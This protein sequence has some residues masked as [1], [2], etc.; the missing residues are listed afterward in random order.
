M[1]TN[2]NFDFIKMPE[3]K[4]MLI[5]ANEALNISNT[6]NKQLIFVYSVPKVGSTTII[7]SLR[8][9][10]LNKLDLIH[11]HDEEMLNVLCHVNGVSI[12]EIILYNKYLGRE[13]FV[14]NIYRSPIERKISA[15]FEKVGSYHF[16][17]SDQNVNT[18][19]VD[20]VINRFNNIF[21]HLD[22]GDHF[23]DKYNIPLPE[24]FDWNKKY[25]LVKHNDITYI[26]LR[27]KDSSSWGQILTELFSTPIKIVKDYESTN[28]PFKELYK[29]FKTKYK[30]PIN[31]LD[32][33]NQCK[34]LNYYYSPIELNEYVQEWRNKSTETKIGYTLDQYKVYKEITM[35]NTYYDNI[36]TDHY[37][38]EG[39]KCKACFL[40]R[41]ELAF[42]IMRGLPVSERITHA[43]AKIQL[44][45]KRVARANKINEVIQKIPLN[46][47]L[48][49]GKNF[50]KEMFN[51]LT[52]KR[53]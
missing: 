2:N 49:S 20:K 15:F 28:K 11:I 39:C 36:Q 45:Q 48:V 41:T 37:I 22:V 47:N 8:I 52:G 13:V 27:L 12:N 21:G 31:Y 43:E 18:Y 4:Y 33:I 5:K 46:N 44:I 3:K 16:N 40:K 17:T 14:I 23:I 38:D 29:S 50:K 42:K 6:E 51:I 7:S 26:S 53:K 34:Y 9:F 19:N 24:H 25:L 10:A 35:E 30:I 32:E 1:I